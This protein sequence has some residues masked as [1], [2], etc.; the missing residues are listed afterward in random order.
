MVFSKD[1]RDINFSAFN[2]LILITLLELK[3]VRLCCQIITSV[4][5]ALFSCVIYEPNSPFQLVPFEGK[6]ED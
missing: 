1:V 5:Y 3:I 6:A 2:F 4:A